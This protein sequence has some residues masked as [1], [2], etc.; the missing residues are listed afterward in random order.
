MSYVG[1]ERHPFP[2]LTPPPSG[3]SQKKVTLCPKKR[4]KVCIL[5]FQFKDDQNFGLATYIEDDHVSPL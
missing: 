4:G 5:C 3:V 2:T 1:G